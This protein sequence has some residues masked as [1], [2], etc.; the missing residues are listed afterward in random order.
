MVVSFR[1][2]D[3]GLI[4]SPVDDGHRLTVGTVAIREDPVVDSNVLEALDDAKRC[5]WE[6]GLDH[7]GR[8]NIVFDRDIRHGRGDG[9]RERFKIYKPN[10]EE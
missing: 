1:G 8:G 5:A 9:G 10:T 3:G 6:D 2:K 7:S 4:F